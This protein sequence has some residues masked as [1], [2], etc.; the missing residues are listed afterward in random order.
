MFLGSNKEK[1][2][3]GDKYYGTKTEEF[4]QKWKR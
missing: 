2:K 4:I 3:N 1:R